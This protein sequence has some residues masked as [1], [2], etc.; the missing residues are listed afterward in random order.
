MRA[1]V[2][3]MLLF[4]CSSATAEEHAER[5][6]YE[7]SWGYSDVARVTLQRGCERDGYRPAKLSA[8]SLG[9]A[10]QL[11]SFTITLDS[12]LDPAGRTLEGRTYIR[13]EGVARRYRTRF[14]EDGKA[15]THKKFKKKQSVLKLSLRPGTFDLLSWAFSL[16]EENLSFGSTYSYFVWD[17]WKLTRVRASVAKKERI[18]TPKGTYD[19]HRIT[20]H[21]E[22]LFHTGS[23]AYQVKK[24]GKKIGTMWL[25]DDTSRAPVAMD[26]SAPVGLAKLRLSRE[27]TSACP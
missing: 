22:R 15:Q 5:Y 26:F 20:L 13:E 17:G 14:A 10:E 18:W 6:D 16:R 24:P 25:R 11:H 1:A 3:I 2:F 19:A 8:K 23:N 12:F 27:K 9:V 21:R 4:C 7:V